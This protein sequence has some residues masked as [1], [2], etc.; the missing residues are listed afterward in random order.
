MFYRRN[1]YF[2][3]L[4]STGWSL[5]F[6][7]KSKRNQKRDLI[8]YQLW[9]LRHMERKR[10]LLEGFWDP[11]RAELVALHNYP[12]H[13]VARAEVLFDQRSYV[14]PALSGWR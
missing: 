8:R 6:L 10:M 1:D 5:S 7:V 11:D 12:L 2:E 4:D 13:D 9:K 3:R 14:H